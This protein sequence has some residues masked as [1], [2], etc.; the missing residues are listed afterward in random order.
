MNKTPIFLLFLLVLLG[1]SMFNISTV[2]AQE[3]PQTGSF[4]GNPTLPNWKNVTVTE[5][6]DFVIVDNA[7]DFIFKFRKRT[8]GYNEIWQDGSQVVANEQWVFQ[9]LAQAQWKQRGIPQYVVCEQPQP[10]HVIVK[11]LY[12]DFI[13]TT[14]NV[15]YEFYG[16][17]R[18]KIGF[19]GYIGQSD[20]YRI[21]WKVSG[22]S[23]TYVENVTNYVKF[24]NEDAE[25]IVFDYTDVYESFGNI[26]TIEIEEW[27][28]NHK[29]TEIF[30][31]GYL[32]S[33]YFELDPNFGYEG[34]NTLFESFENYVRGSVFTITEDGI[35][36]NITA[37]VDLWDYFSLLNIFL[38][39]H[40]KA[41]IY[42]H[43]D[44]SFVGE[45]EELYA[46][47]GDGS[48]AWITWNFNEPKPSLTADTAYILV[49]WGK[50]EPYS[51]QCRLYYVAGDTDQ[52]HYDS[53]T[54]ND[55]PDPLEPVHDNNKYSIYCGYTVIVEE[56]FNILPYILLSLVILTPIGVVAYWWRIENG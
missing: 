28:N 35:A 6:D 56:V 32:E 12:D 11:R 20:I 7:D 29:L 37:Y 39:V 23:K 15:T 1:L 33:G 55:F 31:V 13:G 38:N 52:G 40:T 48:S 34:T 3:E 4:L 10:Y 36:D 2:K 45:T 44:L 30:N 43:G 49:I 24:W 5:N 16:G 53:E 18:V 46:K 25:P 9:Y 26:T 51:T 27:A 19:E 22:I 21:Q 8:A 50:N 14:F 17:F 54:Y 42:E 41:S 47:S